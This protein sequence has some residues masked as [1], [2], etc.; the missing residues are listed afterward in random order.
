MLRR[1]VLGATLGNCVEWFDFG[2]YGYLATTLGAVFFPSDDPTASLLASFAVF[3]IAFIA[4]PLGGAFFGSRGDRI[5]RQRTLAGVILLM[6]AA[7]CAIGLLPG[8]ASIGVAAPALLVVARLL[9]GLSV[10]GEFGGAS[11]FLAEYAP[12]DRRGFF[13]SWVQAS[14]LLGLVLSSS[15]VLLLRSNLSEDAMNAWGWRV[16]FLCAGP[17]GIVG[18][19]LRLKLEDTPEFR[20]LQRAGGVARAPVRETITRSY[21]PM[22]QAI[23]LTIFPNVAFYSVFTYLQTHMVRQLGFSP[24]AAG[25]S[26][27]LTLL[28]AIALVPPLGL[29]SDRIG[30]K[31][32]LVAGCAGYA[33]LSYPAFLL[34]NQGLFVVTTG[35]HIVLGVLLAVYSSAFVATLTELFPPRVRYTG[36]AIGHN[37]AAALFGGVAPFLATYLIAITGNALAPAYYLLAATV[38]TLVTLTTIR[39]T[40]QRPG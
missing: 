9:Q 13:T 36:F 4:R 28:A 3:A 19:Y 25:L 10:G 32:L 27:T 18:L 34:M 8:Y 24:G 20:A 29:L 38:A 6:S 11:T 31:P 1:A 37:L 35:T 16:P 15:M 22:L 33:V 23:G 2:V 12:R 7:T 14:G 40:G 26:T 30:R 39:E 5:G 17:L 21:R